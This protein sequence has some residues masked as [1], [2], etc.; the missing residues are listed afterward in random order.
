MSGGLGLE[1]KLPPP[2]PSPKGLPDTLTDCSA[3]GVEANPREAVGVAGKD[4]EAEGVGLARE[5][6]EA[7]LLPAEEGLSATAVGVCEGE[8][9][10]FLEYAGPEL[11]MVPDTLKLMET[12]GLAVPVA[13]GVVEVERE[14][15]GVGAAEVLPRALA[16]VLAVRDACDVSVSGAV[17]DR[18]PRVDGEVEKVP[19]FMGEAVRESCEEGVA[20]AGSETLPRVLPVM[21]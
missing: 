9:L 16:E 14:A 3:V 13:A 15:E 6:A 21:L 17:G 1:E 18:D 8:G 11:V 2:A 4:S 12:L 5:V 7:T 20:V 19:S 10:L